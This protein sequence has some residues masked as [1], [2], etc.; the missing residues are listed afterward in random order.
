MSTNPDLNMYLHVSKYFCRAIFQARKFEPKFSKT[1]SYKF[2]EFRNT[3][4]LVERSM[5]YFISRL[6]R[7]NRVFLGLTLWR[8]FLERTRTIVFYIANVRRIQTKVQSSYN[9]FLVSE[10][11]TFT[12][13]DRMFTF[14]K[15]ELGNF[16]LNREIWKSFFL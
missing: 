9:F 2:L 11:M 8:L 10:G 6:L 16:I 7:T 1:D 5:T 15:F 4:S 13:H 14:V 3:Y 12:V